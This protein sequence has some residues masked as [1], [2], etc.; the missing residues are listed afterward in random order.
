MDDFLEWFGRISLI[1]LILIAFNSM[2]GD[3]LFRIKYSFPHVSEITEQVI[4]FSKEPVQTNLE[5]EKFIKYRGEK[6]NYVLKPQAQYSISGLVTATNSNFWFRDIMRSDFDDVALLDLGIVWGD[7]AKDKRVL[8]DNISFKSRKTLGQARALYYS[9]KGSAPWGGEYIKSHVSHTHML[10]ANPN[11]MG[12]LLHIKKNDIVKIDGYL[13]DIYT[14][15][16]ET[17]AL[18]SLSR[19]DTNA[20]SRGY[21][22]CED[23]YVKQVQIGNKIYR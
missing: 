10:P 11:V 18:T 2:L 9:W 6:N 7:L 20:S 21:G 4:D 16:S 17:V 8:Y 15:K 12:G 13:V 19:F 5:N 3:I 14:E 1:A 23:M 22:A